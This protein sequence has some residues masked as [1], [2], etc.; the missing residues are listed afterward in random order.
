MLIFNAHVHL[1]GSMSE[2]YLEVTARRNG[3]T[4]HFQGFLAETDLWKKFSWIHQIIQTPED[5][6]LATLDVVKHSTADILEIRTT[7]KAMG[8]HS[9]DAYIQAFVE[10]LREANAQYPQKRARGLLSIDRTKHTLS[11]AKQIIDAAVAE[12]KKSGMI[13]GID[14]SGNFVGPRKL[15]GDGLYQAVMYALQQD[16]GAALHVGEIDS[17]DERRDFDTI[18]RAVQD[19]KEKQ[20][21]K[22]YGKVRFGHAIYRTPE[23]DEIIRKLKI[24]VE[25]CP[26]CHEVLDWW[27]KGQPHPILSLYTHRTRVLAGTDDNLLFRCNDKDEQHKLDSFLHVPEKYAQLS[28]DAQHEIISAKRKRY[29]F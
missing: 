14:L 24:P 7:A 8:R 11:D 3:C 9:V 19:Y 15:T 23:Q 12:K 2:E 4:E 28:E 25:V 21:G 17:E 18:L 13:V 10:G 1:N 5:I 29:M 26:S 27:K 6:K 20:Q 22:I 16:I